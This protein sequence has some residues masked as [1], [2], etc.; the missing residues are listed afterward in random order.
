MSLTS[1]PHPSQHGDMIQ[2]VA[3]I[4]AGA[5]G[6]MYGSALEKILGAGLWFCAEGT[7]LEALKSSTFALNGSP[8]RFAVYAP[9]EQA[10]SP[11]LVLVAV[12]N[13][14]LKEVLPLLRSLIGPQTLVLS[15]LN[16]I[17][18]NRHCHTRGQGGALHGPGHGRPQGRV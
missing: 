6:L 14:H 15:V 16:G 17:S 2:S 1:T 3:I 18:R 5:L 11:D 9:G 8:C 10:K 4:G 13:Y 7:R 12:K